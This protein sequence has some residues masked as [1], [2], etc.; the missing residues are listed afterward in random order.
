VVEVDVNRR[1]GAVRVTRFYAVAELGTTL[2]NPDGVKNQL[3]GGGIM[4]LSRSLKEEARF[5]RRG[6]RSYDWVTY[7][8][9]RFV[10]MPA[11]FDTVVL[12]SPPSIPGGGIGE[13]ASVAVPAAV[14]NAIFDATGVRMRSIPFT[15]ARV[16]AALRAAAG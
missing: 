10:D 14:G 9:F 1:T 13:P 7:P 15:P 16:R 5:S 11:V 3:E 2:V 12:T 8:I 6:V 4:G